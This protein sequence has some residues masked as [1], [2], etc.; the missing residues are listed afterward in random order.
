MS[1]ASPTRENV[2]PLLLELARAFRARQFYPSTHPAMRDALDR[3]SGL[4]I[5]AL[6]RTSEIDL[7]FRQASF[8][9]P[10]GV[11]LRG[12]GIDTLAGEL[13]VRRVRRLRVLPGVDPIEIAAL[14]ETL[15]IDADALASLGGFQ[16][17]LVE[18]GVRHV[19]TE[20]PKP[21]DETPISG[22]R[23]PEPE[24]QQLTT[25]EKVDLA[26]P[27]APSRAP[28]DSDGSVAL[29]RL[30]AELEVCEESGVY[31]E[32]ADGI[33]STVATLLRGGE[34]QEAYRAL[35]VY[36]R[37][38]DQFQR[39]DEIRREA[40]G[41]LRALVRDRTL[42]D[43][44]LRQ[45]CE[46]SGLRSV[47]A[48]QAL[49]CIGPSVVPQ[50]LQRLYTSE[51]KA[52][53]QTTSVLIALGEQALPGVVDELA[54]TEPERARRAARLLGEMQNPFGVDFLI[55]G[56]NT[57]DERVRREVARALARIGNERALRGL[58]ETLH[59]T[60]IELACIAATAL[61]SA[62]GS[63]AVAALS[64]CLDEKTLTNEEV[65]REA[66]RS[67]GR[68][69]SDAGI[70]ALVQV[71][72]QGSL[73][74][75]RRFRERQLLAAQ[76]LSRISGP[77]ARAALEKQRDTGSAEIRRTCEAALLR[78]DLGRTH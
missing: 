19:T 56:L 13:R 38:A 8:V 14:V 70:P 20:D 22:P 48:I 42:L 27:P 50:L 76:A 32:L 51:S 35:L 10:D 66:I 72:A 12:P 60:D 6:S 45:A 16:Q 26:A 55:E 37:H 1:Q 7:S 46:T 69:G 63:R 77:A 61:G 68:I 28:M 24:P 53:A 71:L 36:T 78:I 64:S 17:A 3:V 58:T 23:Y 29:V 9:L 25:A 34:Q 52:H 54:A 74:H 39:R 4:W 31:S 40:R 11:E 18:A 5:A 49:I 67:L 15:V 44:V 41:R 33:A 65:R 2:A 73:L 62:R 43:F 59:R 57:R 30:L 21:D 75:R 47:Q